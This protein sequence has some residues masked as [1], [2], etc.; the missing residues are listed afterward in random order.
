MVREA[1]PAKPREHQLS[2]NEMFQDHV[3][4]RALAKNPSDRHQ[5]PA[6]LLRDLDRI[7]KYNNLDADWSEWVG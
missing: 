4:M 6:E 2:I 3:V 7:G 1:E 5:T